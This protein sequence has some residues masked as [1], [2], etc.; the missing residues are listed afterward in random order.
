MKDHLEYPNKKIYGII[1]CESDVSFDNI[2]EALYQGYLQKEHEIWVSFNVAKGDFPKER[3]LNNIVGWVVSGS[4]FA[5]YDT[6]LLWLNDLFKLLNDIYR[7]KGKNSKILGICFGHQAIAKAFGGEVEKMP[8]NRLLLNKQKIYWDHKFLG[9]KYVKKSQI[10][11]DLLQ[12]NDIFLNQY[13]GDH[14]SKLPTNAEIF[15]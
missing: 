13:H 8:S 3:D 14:V 10:I 2:F 12:K 6:N 9:K 11:V 7:V 5:T 1:D 15:A 4:D